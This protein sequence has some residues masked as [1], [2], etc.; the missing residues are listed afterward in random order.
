LV[1]VLAA[2][3][4]TAVKNKKNSCVG[5]ISTTKY[6]IITF[7]PKNLFEQFHRLANVYFLFIVIL[8]WLP[9]IQAFGREVAMIPLI[10]VLLVTAVKDA[11]EDR[12][13]TLLPALLCP[14]ANDALFTVSCTLSCERL[15]KE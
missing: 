10:F 15:S 3:Q 2:E 13:A 1:A 14:V 6:N 12:C 9:P 5:R 11:Y 7:L 8:N 4:K